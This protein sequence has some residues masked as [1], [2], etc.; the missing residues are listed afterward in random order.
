MSDLKAARIRA[1]AYRLWEQ[2]GRPEGEDVTHWLNAEAELTAGVAEDDESIS[3]PTRST[4]PGRP[5]DGA[6]IKGGTKNEW[7]KPARVESW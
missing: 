1:R 6:R 4:T 3:D 5:R 7:F 2:A